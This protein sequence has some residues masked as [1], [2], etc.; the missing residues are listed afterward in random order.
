MI[1][2]YGPIVDSVDRQARARRVAELWVEDGEY[3]IGGVHRCKGREA[4]A[5]VFEERHFE[6]VPEGVCHVKGLP[7]VR[8]KGTRRAR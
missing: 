7:F 1:A 6:Q 4:I 3:D 5:A 2:S 8:V